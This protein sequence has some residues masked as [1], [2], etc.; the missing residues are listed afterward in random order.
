MFDKGTFRVRPSILDS[1]GVGSCNHT[2][3]LFPYEKSCELNDP[4]RSA[5]AGPVILVVFALRIAG[6]QLR[7]ERRQSAVKSRMRI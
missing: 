4:S 6:A 1:F 5:S 3:A 7:P 2:L